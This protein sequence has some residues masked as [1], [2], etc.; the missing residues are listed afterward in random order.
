MMDWAVFPV[1]SAMT[2]MIKLSFL[3]TA[4]MEDLQDLGVEVVHV[5][6]VPDPQHKAAAI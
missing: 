4:L 6:A 1:L 3:Q 5:E 2:P